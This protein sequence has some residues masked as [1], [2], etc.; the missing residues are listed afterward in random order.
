MEMNHVERTVFGWLE[1]SVDIEKQR[2]VKFFNFSSCVRDKVKVREGWHKNS[3]LITNLVEKIPLK[4][5]NIQVFI[6]LRHLLLL[7]IKH[8]NLP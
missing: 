6:Y 3:W 8:F 7:Q 2:K 5:A 1:K 4:F